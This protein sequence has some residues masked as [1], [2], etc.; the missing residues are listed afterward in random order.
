MWCHVMNFSVFCSACV[1]VSGCLH[2]HQVW[3]VVV[4]SFSSVLCVY[5]VVLWL[6]SFWVP[7]LS[8]MN[9]FA[10]LGTNRL[11]DEYLKHVFEM[12]MLLCI[13]PYYEWKLI[14]KHFYTLEMHEMM[15]LGPL[16]FF[17]Q[18]HWSW[19]CQQWEV[20]LC[21]LWC[22]QTSVYRRDICL[23]PDQDHLLCSDKKIQVQ[24]CGWL[25]SR[26]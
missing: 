11:D 24:P 7:L 5:Y 2:G 9:Y 3:S 13:W 25:F 17:Q 14:L 18:I 6:C 19:G 22:W 12:F 10:L 4:Y 23:R 26:D 21:P 1:V 20:C 8:F 16:N 15:N